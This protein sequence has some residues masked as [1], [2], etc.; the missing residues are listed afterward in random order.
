M[1]LLNVSV[2]CGLLAR[3]SKSVGGRDHGRGP[4][5]DGVD[6]LGA[7]DAAEVDRVDRK[8]GMSELALDATRGTPSRDI[9]TA[10]A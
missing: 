1:V 2:T 3:C 4:F 10:W 7:V 8:V 6:D 5:V 9:S